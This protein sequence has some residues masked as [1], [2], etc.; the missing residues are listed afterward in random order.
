MNSSI[1]VFADVSDEMPKLVPYE[2]KTLPPKNT[3]PIHQ[4]LGERGSI[5]ESIHTSQLKLFQSN[6]FKAKNRNSVQ[7][8]LGKAWVNPAVKERNRIALHTLKVVKDSPQSM[9]ESDKDTTILLKAFA[10]AINRDHLAPNQSSEQKYNIKLQKEI[11]M[12]QVS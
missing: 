2:M 10:K 1:D 8:R 5:C 7:N 3:K 12:M 6:K 11:S 4:R 9:I